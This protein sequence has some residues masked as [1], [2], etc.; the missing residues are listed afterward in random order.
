MMEQVFREIWCKPKWKPW[1]GAKSFSINIPIDFYRVAFTDIRKEGMK[2][3]EERGKERSD[4][5][6]VEHVAAINDL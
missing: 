5:F 2:A 4:T 1:I 3:K 6:L